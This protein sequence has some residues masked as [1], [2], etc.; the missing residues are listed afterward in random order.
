MGGRPAIV[1]GRLGKPYRA[2][3]KE[4]TLSHFK[5]GRSARRLTAGAG[6]GLSLLVVGSGPAWG[7]RVATYNLD[8]DTSDFASNNQSATLETVLEGINSV[9]LNDNGTPTAQMLDVLGVQELQ[10]GF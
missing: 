9:H 10:N 1:R 5:R 3:A 7:L 2:R 6:I 4:L 8:A